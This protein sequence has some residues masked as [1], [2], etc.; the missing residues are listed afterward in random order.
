MRPAR[1]PFRL[2]VALFATTLLGGATFGCGG[3]SDTA[4]V[5]LVATVSGTLSNAVFLSVQVNGPAGMSKPQV[6]PGTPVVLFPTTLTAEIPGSATGALTFVLTALRADRSPAASGQA[7]PLWIGRGSSPTVYVSLSCGDKPCIPPATGGTPDGGTGMQPNCGNGIVDPNETCDTSIPA[8]MP[9]ACPPA[10]CDDGLACTKDTRSGSGCTASCTHTE[11]ATA[12]SVSDG[13][14]PTGANAATDPDCSP[15]C[16]NGTVDPGET[17]DLALPPGAVGACP[18][19]LDC[20]AANACVLAQLISA[21]TCS[22]IC[23]RTPITLPMSND[24][25][26][27]AG[28]SNAIDNDCPAACGDGIRGA[29]ETC[30]VGIRPPA[31]GSCP[32]SCDD[33]DP[34]TTDVLSGAGCQ[35]LCIHDRITTAISGDGC[36][37]AGSTAATD[38]D[39][40]AAC[41]DGVLEPG[42]TCD[43]LA[44]DVTGCPTVC[45]PSPAACLQTALTGDPATCTAACLSTAI[46]TCGPSD[47]CCP[48]G[49]GAAQDPDCS[50]T[51][52]DGLVSAGETCDVAIAAGQPGACPT[53]CPDGDPC[54]DD[55][56][57][58]AGTCQAA[59]LHLPVTAARTGDG[60]CPPGADFLV[61]AD[62]APSCGNGVVERPVESCDPGSPG[63]CPTTCP[64]T[65]SCATVALRGNP[66]TCSAACVVTPIV[67]CATGDGCCPAG[68]TAATDGDCHTI[69]GNGLLEAGEACD[70]AITPGL[71][72]A[73][74]STCDDA[75]A[76]TIDLPV[77]SVA[78]CTRACSHAAVT[79]CLN[80]DGCCPPG[81]TAYSD[82][83]CAPVCNDGRIEA[84]E[85]CDPP[86]TC[87]TTCPDDGDACTIER[88]T[89]DP[90]QC[91]AACRHDPITSCSGARRDGCCPSTCTAATD[92][93]C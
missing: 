87:P 62:C 18:S 7:G 90:Q 33:G 69:C 59:C 56:L 20:T 77:G 41:G 9:G 66:A 46:T 58:S 43:P 74:P 22:A 86:A 81:C 27:P 65:G 84:G 73:C 26:C 50:P 55:R 15:T 37:L 34:C 28:A 76:C 48:A 80:G 54:T 67:A 1:V 30:D 31:S 42:E 57:L 63:S 25:C 14:C 60:C 53:V 61:D 40:P 12:A 11:I 51:C 36:C 93:D 78:S 82:S 3:R 68:C 39:C 79:A 32:V 88:L 8:G 52:G 85:T 92:A 91:N 35:A 17:C 75:N 71:P 70:R 44:T 29:G 24:G 72:G 64:T 19:R 10:T 38:S 21:R 89:G 4:V 49:C 6:Y 2:A 5:L 47:G 23:L 13:C 83:D 45:P 16:G